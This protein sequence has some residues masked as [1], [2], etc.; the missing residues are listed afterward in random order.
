MVRKLLGPLFIVAF[1][2]VIA[3]QQPPQNP[4]IVVWAPHTI[5]AEKIDA[6]MN[7]KIKTEGMERS[8]IMWIEHQLTDV[9][10]PRPIGSPNHKA[11]AD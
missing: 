3:A 7:A 9:Y 8:K 6:E 11:A 5:T 1:V 10:G 2:A 4:S